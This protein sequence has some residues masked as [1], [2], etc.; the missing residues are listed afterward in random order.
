[1]TND[2]RMSQPDAAARARRVSMIGAVACVFA[3][4]VG[5]CSSGGAA[6]GPLGADAGST[7][8]KQSSSDVEATVGKGSS[9][10]TVA[11]GGLESRSTRP[12]N[13][14]CAALAACCAVLS[15][16]NSPR[17]VLGCETTAMDDK[18]DACASVLTTI[19]GG[20]AC[21]S[22]TVT[23][24]I[25]GSPPTLDGSMKD[26]G[27]RMDAAAPGP[28]FQSPSCSLEGAP[29]GAADAGSCCFNDCNNGACGGS[30]AEG[31]PCTAAGPPCADNLQCNAGFCGTNACVPDG[32]TCGGKTDNVC[33]NNNC[34]GTVC[35]TF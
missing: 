29:C 35:G 19:Q 3:I 9:S 14:E 23:G 33:C 20:G 13:A 7:A 25:A 28:Q 15:G 34:T 26:D 11:T 17:T 24:T 2:R 10:S 1:M 18:S 6:P 16:A 21:T 22:I 27:P 4:S 12:L 8:P 32:T 5:A 30:L 31:Q